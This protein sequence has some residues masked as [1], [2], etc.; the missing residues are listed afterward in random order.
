MLLRSLVV[1]V[2]RMNVCDLR[3]GIV[4]QLSNSTSNE[5]SI[6]IESARAS[7]AFLATSADPR[8]STQLASSSTAAAMAS[9]FSLSLK[10]REGCRSWFCMEDSSFVLGKRSRHKK[11][12][13]GEGGLK[14]SSQGV[15]IAEREGIDRL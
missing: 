2:F 14:G 13:D 1:H 10:S 5:L 12:L 7:R 15:V 4:H 9:W 8:A 3:G 11:A 6:I